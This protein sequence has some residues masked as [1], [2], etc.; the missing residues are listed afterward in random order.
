M[1]VFKLICDYVRNAPMVLILSGMAVVLIAI[2]DVGSAVD[3]LDRRIYRRGSHGSVIFNTDCGSWV[4][5]GF[6]GRLIICFGI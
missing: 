5:I 1:H 4:A 3:Q 6:I 2:P